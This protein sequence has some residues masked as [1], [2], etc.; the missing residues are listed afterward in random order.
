VRIF[1]LGNF[2]FLTSDQRQSRTRAK[3][4][5]GALDGDM[6]F[7]KAVTLRLS[8]SNSIFRRRTSHNAVWSRFE[9]DEPC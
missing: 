9:L 8:S 3:T 1:A 4:D 7:R 2:A 5:A 6:P